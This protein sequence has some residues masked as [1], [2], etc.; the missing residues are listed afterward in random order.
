MSEFEYGWKTNTDGTRTPLLENERD[1]FVKMIADADQ[2]R[3]AAYPTT[4]DA[5]R[6]FNDADQRLTDLGWRKSTFGF[7]NG[8]ELAL[9]EKG[10]TGVFRAVWHKP[11]LHYQGCVAESG[12]HY[13]KRITD[14]TPDEL[15]KMNE[16]EEYHAERMVY[17]TASMV[18]L[19]EIMNSQ[20]DGETA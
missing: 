1:A 18:R 6:A 2:R 16:C 3:A 17:E 13:I 4:N 7:E 5:L 19:S 8:A 14:L 20:D 9:V 15:A 11:Y 12:K 10:S